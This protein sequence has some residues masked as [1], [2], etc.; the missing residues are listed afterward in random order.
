M[1][2][3]PDSFLLCFSIHAYIFLARLEITLYH[4]RLLSPVSCKTARKRKSR[5]E[6]G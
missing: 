6:L 5:S 3:N 2:Y 4:L 1:V